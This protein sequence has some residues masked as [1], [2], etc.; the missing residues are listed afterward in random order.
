MAASF[1]QFKKFIVHHDKCAM[2][3]GTDGVLL[4]AWTSAERSQRVLDIGTG[5]GLIALMLAQ[6]SEALIHAIDID[7]QAWIQA[8]ENI[9]ES[10]FSERIHVFQS[11][12]NEYAAQTTE[13]YDL[14]VSNPPYFKN[15][16]RSPVQERNLARHNDSLT[17]KSLIEDSLKIL[18]P[19]GSLSLILPYDQEQ[20][21]DTL[22]VS[23]H[24]YFSRKTY[25]R[26]IPETACKRILVTLTTNKTTCQSDELIIE[27]SRH[28]YTQEYIALTKDF[29]LKM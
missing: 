6:R 7:H 25:V 1:F 21:L 13:R 10:I 27:E 28:N 9:S 23:F 22:A 12:L 8:K 18:A 17:L 2:K 24:L 4:G 20:D 15:S 16:L 26:P 11:S 3:V 29:Y 5:S 19:Q 14:I